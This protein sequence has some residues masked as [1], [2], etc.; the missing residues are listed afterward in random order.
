[1]RFDAIEAISVGALEGET[2]ELAPGLNVIH[3]V[4][5]AGK[6]TWHGALIA[7]WLGLRRGKGAQ[8]TED[9]AF[10]THHEPWS[11][12]PLVAAVQLTTDAG[13]RY[14][15]RHNLTDLADHEV[16]D[17]T[18]RNVTGDWEQ[19]GTAD[20]ARIL[21]LSRDVVRATL[22]VSQADVLSITAAAEGL[23]TELQR[24][25][26]AADRSGGT[27]ATALKKLDSFRREQVGT[28]RANAV[29]PLRRAMNGVAAAKQALS[30]A[31]QEHETYL[32]TVE[33]RDVASARIQELTGQREELQQSLRAAELLR[34]RTEFEELEELDAVVEDGK[35]LSRPASEDVISVAEQVRSR[36]ADRPAAVEDDTPTRIRE[37]ET[38][39]A[40][41][42]EMP[43]GDVRVHTSVHDAW[44]ALRGRRERLASHQ[45]RQPQMADAPQLGEISP[46]ELERHATTF[47]APLP[48][49]EPQLEERLTALESAT[50][51]G[52]RNPTAAFA[53]AVVIAVLIAAV[54]LVIAQPIVTGV[55][56]AAAAAAGVGAVLAQRRAGDRTSSARELE[57]LR[58]QKAAQ[59]AE[60]RSVETRQ[61]AARQTLAAAGLDIDEAGKLRRLA[62]QVRAA[63]RAR[64]ELEQWELDR[65]RAAGLVEEA[66]EQLR[67]ALLAR[68]EPN[69]DELDATYAAYRERCDA[70]DEQARKAGKRSALESS[71][72]SVREL[73]EQRRRQR[74]DRQ[75]TEQALLE[76]ARTLG[77]QGDHADD[78]DRFLEAWL[79]DQRLLRKRTSEVENSRTKLTAR[80][81]DRTLDQLRDQVGTLAAEIGTAAA[82]KDPDA[83][84]RQLADVEMERRQQ[85]ARRDE[86]NGQLRELAR[87]ATPVPEAEESLAQAQAEL[88]R[89]QGLGEVLDITRR[90]LEDANQRTNQDIAPVLRGAVAEH[91]SLVTRNRYADVQVTPSTLEVTVL[92]DGGRY[93][94]ATALSHGTAEQIYLLLRI[95]LAQHLV[96]SEE[97]APIALD[98]ISVQ[99]DE[100]RTVR[101]LELCLQ[102]AQ[103]RQILLFSQE[104]EV[105]EWAQAKLSGPEHRLHELADPVQVLK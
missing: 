1:M 21:G 47:E 87:N 50:R 67:A 58:L 16:T 17:G 77:F 41:L 15:F 78:A 18:G 54:G 83:C 86:L 102:L 91:L 76:R 34:L 66:T 49:V 55:A 11:G 25:A 92:T 26:A 38:E 43:T 75:D 61:A 46:D 4:N 59:L 79:A 57:Q 70:R 88:D 72:A 19:G 2:L 80:L 36:F 10:V 64:R 85:E 5:E 74:Q 60:R 103:Q 12:K 9:R 89:V 20:G 101:V 45:E 35:Q 48:D 27:T 90:F 53:A 52:S 37:L 31:Q 23:Q 98:D 63:D 42:P 14:R 62:E 82:A 33:E 30:R 69:A 8:R 65:S 56:L 99:F 96:T 28:S 68:E 40:G 93:R 73:A 71:L 97:T 13:L 6:S 39:L 7:G 84:R 32:D 22:V 24:A 94:P 100:H 51:G 105:L 81:G 3:G 29:K 104:R 44:D 95:G